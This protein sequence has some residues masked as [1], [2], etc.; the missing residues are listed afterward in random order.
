L[1]KSGPPQPLKARDFVSS[2]GKLPSNY[3]PKD[4]ARM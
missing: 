1:R 2:E 3:P 4:V